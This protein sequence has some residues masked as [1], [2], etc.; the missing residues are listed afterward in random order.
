ML[1]PLSKGDNSSIANYVF[2]LFVE[3]F[4]PLENFS[5]IWRRHH[6][7]C[8]WWAV[9]FDLCSDLMVTEQ[10]GFFIL[11]HLLWHQASVYNTHTLIRAFDSG[12]VTTCF[13]DLGLWR[14]GFKH[15]T[16]RF[17]N[18]QSNPLRHRRGVNSV[19]NFKNHPHLGEI[20]F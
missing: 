19:N 6:T 12:A 13:Q 5:L 2:Y 3:F 7:I 18:E 1:C 9:N 14:L 15:P 20:I 4:V 17:R 10:W 11:S 16:F 8:R